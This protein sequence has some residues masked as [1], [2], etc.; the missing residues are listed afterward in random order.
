MRPYRAGLPW[1]TETGYRL[2]QS[3]GDHGRVDAADENDA[4]LV[5]EFVALIAQC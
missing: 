3:Y 5:E 1:L 2:R 4:A